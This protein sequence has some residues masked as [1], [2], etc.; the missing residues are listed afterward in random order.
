MKW[1][2]CTP[3]AFRGDESFFERDSGLWS[4]ALRELGIESR[5]V[6]PLPGSPSDL[7][8]LLR[9]PPSRLESASWWR[10]LGIDG[11]ILYSWGLPRYTPV[12]RAIRGAG[13]QLVIY[14]D[15]NGEMYPWRYWRG[16]TA[17]MR[18]ALIHRFGPWAGAAAFAAKMVYAHAVKPFAYNWRQRAHL[19]LADR[20]GVPLPHTRE[21]YRSMRFLYGDAMERLV[22][23]P[24]PVSGSFHRTGAPQED[25]LVCIGRWDDDFAKRPR[26][27]MRCIEQVL[28]KAPSL[29]VA[30]CGN[31]TDELHAW[32]AQLP[33]ELRGRI[34]WKGY[35]Q[36]GELP[37]LLNRAR[38]VLCTSRSE[39]THFASAEALCCGCSVVAPGH[40]G[41]EALRWYASG[42]SGTIARSDA[43]EDL[44]AALL[45][46]REEW[47]AGR[48][49]PA[50]IS[51]LWCSRLHATSTLRRILAGEGFSLAREPGVE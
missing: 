7:P 15:S 8:E 32:L 1:Y 9:V 11:V 30:L 49:D 27:M 2:T 34:E 3:V 47:N 45:A 41:L 6:M 25:L 26:L 50:R 22:L 40:Y 5:A 13:L 24:A 31:E 33:D 4:R 23:M 39:S 19:A 17:L 18:D 42:A 10:S 44:V 51:S 35:V 20:I 37:A 43:P 16:G 36:H 29:H 48:R 21:V 38:M 12:A 46:E 14:L 28:A